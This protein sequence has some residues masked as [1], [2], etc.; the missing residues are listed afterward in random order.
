[1][2]SNCVC[3]SACVCMC[4]GCMMCPIFA[5]SQALNFVLF[6]PKVLPKPFGRYSAIFN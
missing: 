5:L 4:V 1:M 6:F 3:A 2:I